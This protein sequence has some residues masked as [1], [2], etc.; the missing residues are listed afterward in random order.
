M[1]KNW[2]ILSLKKLGDLEISEALRMINKDDILVLYDSKSLYS[3][4]EADEISE[5]PAIGTAYAFKKY[6]RDA[7]CEIFIS[8][9]WDESNRSAFLTVK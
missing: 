7:V 8:G 5:W 9:R 4:A 3:S 2:K 6:I 1:K